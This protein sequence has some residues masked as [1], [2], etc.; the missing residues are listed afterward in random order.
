MI[1]TNNHRGRNYNGTIQTITNNNTKEE[2]KW[3]DT[4]WHT[5]T[6]EYTTDSICTI[7]IQAQK[8]SHYAISSKHTNRI[9]NNSVTE[10]KK[11]QKYFQFFIF[12]HF[13][14]QEN[15]KKERESSL[16]TTKQEVMLSTLNCETKQENTNADPYLSYLVQPNLHG[17]Q[18]RLP[19]LKVL[20]INIFS[21][22]GPTQK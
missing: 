11:C 6:N 5:A 2:K 3:T 10:L 20:W 4:Y 17:K 7:K 21:Y 16:E 9:Y 14:F 22:S 15:E 19:S 1:S 13:E 12:L 8:Q 18:Q